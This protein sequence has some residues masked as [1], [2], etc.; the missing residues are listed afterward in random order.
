MELEKTNI[1]KEKIKQHPCLK[2]GFDG[3]LKFWHDRHYDDC[4][5]ECPGC[6]RSFSGGL[7]WLDSGYVDAVIKYWNPKNDPKEELKRLEAS[8]A[9]IPDRVKEIKSSASSIRDSIK[10]IKKLIS[11]REKS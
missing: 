1:N 4:T 2:C 9:S 5:I 7:S 6:G 8:L 11:D 3:T 10:S